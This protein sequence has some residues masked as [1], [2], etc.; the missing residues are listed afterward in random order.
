MISPHFSIF[1]NTDIKIK[2]WGIEENFFR[3]NYAGLICYSMLKEHESASV[4]SL[5]KRYPFETV[6]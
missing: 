2:K 6:I 1:G 4:P 5:R 3:K